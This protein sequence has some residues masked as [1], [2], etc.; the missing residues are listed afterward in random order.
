MHQFRRRAHGVSASGGFRAHARRQSG[1]H[2]ERVG[3]TQIHELQGPDV[4]AEEHTGVRQH[5]LMV[6]EVQHQP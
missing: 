4:A 3:V 5:L 6:A 1:P 2:G